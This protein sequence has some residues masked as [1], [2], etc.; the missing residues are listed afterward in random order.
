MHREVP[1]QVNA[2]VDEGVA[3]LVLALNAIPGIQTLDSC[4]EDPNHG[5]ASVMFCTHD[6]A[7]LYVTVSRLAQAIGDGPRGCVSL[8]L[9]WGSD[10]APAIA[11]LRCPPERLSAVAGAVRAN[12]ARTTP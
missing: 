12:A 7:E 10:G 11:D 1:V 9:S 6:E 4:Q 2:W 5:Q 3:D 8:S